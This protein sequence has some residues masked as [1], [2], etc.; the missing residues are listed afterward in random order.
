MTA[1]RIEIDLSKIR[2]NTRVLVDQLACY[3]ISVA[4]VT[5]AVCGDPA[6]AKA[7]LE[8][9]ASV[10]ADARIVNVVRMRD[11]GI[12]CPIVMIRSPMLSELGQVVQNCGTSYNTEIDVI[13][14]LSAISHRGGK[15]H[16]VILMVEMGDMRDGI[17]PDDLGRISSLVAGMPGVALKGI[18]ANFACLGNV[19]PD[20]EAMAF[21]SQLAAEIE[22]VCSP[23]LETVSGGSSASLPWALGA[24]AKGRINE[25]RLGEAILLGKEPVSGE[26]IEGLQTD[27]F[28]L[29]VE[30]IETKSKANPVP[31]R[32]VD[33]T[34]ATLR[35]VQGSLCK[36]RVVI[37]L[38]MQD[39]DVCGL[40]FPPEVSYIGAT[41]DHT[42]LEDTEGALRVGDEIRCQMTYGALMRAMNARDVE[43]VH[44]S[45]GDMKSVV[46]E[47]PIRPS[48]ALVHGL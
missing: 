47:K 38:G 40:T 37:A 46:L 19:S 28:T 4:A 42:V 7:M 14:G 2:Q 27:A 32:L 18:G 43:T 23:G 39:T 31:L 3:G 17:M 8:G 34:Q 6:V 22:S 35:V 5:K 20:A 1:P 29:V 12:M 21:F 36:K 30:V 11:A 9:G 10:L 25:L 15:A 41:S 48:M 13:A 44:L 33:P 26:P 45:G 24:G 16:N